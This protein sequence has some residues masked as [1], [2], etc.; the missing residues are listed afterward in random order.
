M[1]YI[2]IKLDCQET[3]IDLEEYSIIRKGVDA[4]GTP[5][6]FMWSRHTSANDI[7]ISFFSTEDRDHA[8]SCIAQFLEAVEGFDAD[9]SN[10]DIL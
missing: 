6:V 9:K 10:I 5:T 1:H 7:Y 8:Y 2:Q 4:H 3:L